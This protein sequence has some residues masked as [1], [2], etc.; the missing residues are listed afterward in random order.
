MSNKNFLSN[1]K[2]EKLINGWIIIIEKKN[3][4]KNLLI[5]KF[6]KIFSLLKI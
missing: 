4:R 5:K 3:Y 6:Q 2:V 1:K